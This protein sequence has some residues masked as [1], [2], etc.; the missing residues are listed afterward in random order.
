MT[1]STPVGVPDEQAMVR[2]AIANLVDRFAIDPNEVESTVQ[3]LVREWFERARVKTFVGIIAERH[4]R[5]EL[6]LIPIAATKGGHTT[7]GG[8]SS[9]D[10]A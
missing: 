6:Q 7:D 4:A 8:V 1:T 3:R 5:T 2:A 10:R 9:R